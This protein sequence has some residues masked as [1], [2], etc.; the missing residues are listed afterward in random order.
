M[1]NVG[2]QENSLAA[3]FAFMSIM[4]CFQFVEIFSGINFI[5]LFWIL[6]SFNV[7]INFRLLH[8]FIYLVFYSSLCMTSYIVNIVFFSSAVDVVKNILMF[9]VLSAAILLALESKRLS[10]TVHV[11][12]NWVFVVFVGFV[13]MYLIGTKSHY[14][15][16]ILPEYRN[17]YLVISD[18]V[19]I[20]CIVQFTAFKTGWRYLILFFGFMLILLL[21]S[22]S[23]MLFMF[24]SL[25][26]SFLLSSGSKF[27]IKFHDLI[28]LGV[29]FFSIGYYVLD[30]VE[31]FYRLVSILDLEGDSSKVARSEL[32]LEFLEKLD[33]PR[34][35]LFGCGV[36]EVGSY[37]HNILS[38]W[39]LFGIISFAIFT[40]LVFVTS[41]VLFVRRYR[42][43]Y[44]YPLFIF[45]CLQLF[46]S[47]S[48][49]SLVFPLLF[50]ICIYVVFNFRSV[51]RLAV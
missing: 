14:S 10:T 48:V 15:N 7:L 27:K 11:F 30:N 32:Q 19:A 37:V 43:Q 45:C 44:I 38:I 49:V 50:A 5:L 12:I 40:L 8:G 51:Q 42:F 9:F 4:Y 24:A 28:I 41:V 3:I 16:Y 25:V 20:T 39:Q 47:R 18:A 13:V 29:G 23:T 2:V 35:F 26:V 21:G 1:I 17:S 36:K 33:N 46:F 31:M 6:I 34:C 22:R